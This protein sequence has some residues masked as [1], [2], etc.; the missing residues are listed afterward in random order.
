M[1]LNKQVKK[2]YEKS[3]ARNFFLKNAVLQ[4]RTQ[5]VRHFSSLIQT[6]LFNTFIRNRNLWAYERYETWFSKL[7]NNDDGDS[8]FDIRWR[9]EFRMKH[10]TFLQIVQ[11]VRPRLEKQDTQLRKAIPIEK[12]V[13]VALWRLS[14][15][16]SF[17]SIE[18][19]FS[20]GKSTAVQTTAEFCKE[21]VRL[22][23]L[24]IKF[25]SNRRDIAE[26]IV[27][28][29]QDYQSELP[30]VVGAIDG[31]HIPIQNPS[32]EGKAD[33]FSRTQKYTIGLQGLVRSN[34]LFLDVA[35]GF[36]GSCHDS[37]NLRNSS[38]F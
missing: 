28:F 20:I 11:L 36:P 26:A 23:H 19:T 31:T 33:Y 2:K 25:P 10:S 22:S 8:K 7:M 32:V 29:K 12:R 15:R 5:R 16:N 14:T 34:L 13:G 4:F 3:K 38:L 24:F 21:I 6:T 35:T 37:R 9:N 30:Q 1:A 18:K 27:K 17:R